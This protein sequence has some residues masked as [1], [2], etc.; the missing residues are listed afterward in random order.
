MLR[1]PPRST[2]FPYTTLFRSVATQRVALNALIFL[3]REFLG[4]PLEELQ[5][6]P[7]R[8]PKKLPVVFSPD[9]ATRAIANLEGEYKLIAMLIYGAGLRISETLRLRVKDVDFGMQ[10]L[11]VREGKGGKDRITLL[12]ERLIEP[13][14]KQNHSTLLQHQVD[15]GPRL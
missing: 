7:A 10:Q 8:K 12:P 13:L 1:R 4:A 5:Y 2:L 6:E 9:E 15:M 14:Q 3:Y 11:I